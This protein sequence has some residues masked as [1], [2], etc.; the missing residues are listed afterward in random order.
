[1]IRDA[2]ERV[3]QDAVRARLG[4]AALDGQ[5]P[6]GMR[7]VPR[8]AAVSLLEPGDHELRAHGAVAEQRP[9]QERVAAESSFG[10]RHVCAS[11]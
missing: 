11:A 7:Q 8:L 10:V 2:A 6:L 4:V 1:M 3:G 5:H 9:F